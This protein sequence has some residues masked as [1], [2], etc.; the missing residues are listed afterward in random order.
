M[1]V[2]TWILGA[3]GRSDNMT[4]EERCRT[5]VYPEIVER[6]RSG[7]DVTVDAYD[8]ETRERGGAVT[9]RPADSRVIVLDGLWACHASI[10]ATLD[11]ALMVEAEEP[12]LAAR[13]REFYHWK[14]D[15]PDAA[16]RLLSARAAEEWPA[17]DRQKAGVDAVVSAGQPAVAR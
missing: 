9:Y 12:V 17:V 11:L 15:A 3:S 13:F 14:G 4:S 7:L 2:G 1:S 5:S 10:R 6:L 16:E 8:P